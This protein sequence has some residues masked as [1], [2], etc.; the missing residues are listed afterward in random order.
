MIILTDLTVEILRDY[1]DAYCDADGNE[2]RLL[3]AA[4]LVGALD[5]ALAT[6]EV[7]DGD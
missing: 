2:E 5:M 7:K 3:I 4:R 1:I 6:A